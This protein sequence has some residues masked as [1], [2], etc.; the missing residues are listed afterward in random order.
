[1]LACPWSLSLFVLRSPPSPFAN[2][3]RSVHL[4]LL[5]SLNLA[6]HN[7]SLVWVECSCW[8]WKWSTIFKS[9]E[10]IRI[11]NLSDTVK[12]PLSGHPWDQK[13]WP[14]KRAVF[15]WE[16]KNAVS[17]YVARNMTKCPHTSRKRPLFLVPKGVRLREVWLCFFFHKLLLSPLNHLS[18]ACTVI[19]FVF[20]SSTALRER[21]RL[22]Q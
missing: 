3:F 13:K 21:W 4:Q 14:L 7:F 22:L 5:L 8:Q 10:K 20:C 11:E 12:P 16:V 19:I 1:M 15:L 17:L 6:S 18:T 9:G 2:Q